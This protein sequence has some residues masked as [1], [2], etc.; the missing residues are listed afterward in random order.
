MNNKYLK[1]HCE[2]RN[3]AGSQRAQFKLRSSQLQRAVAGWHAQCSDKFI[4]SFIFHADPDPRGL[5]YCESLGT[6]SKQEVGSGVK[7]NLSQPYRSTDSRYSR[8][9][10]KKLQFQ[11]TV[12]IPLST[13]MQRPTMTSSETFSMMAAASPATR[14]SSTGALYRFQNRNSSPR[15]AVVEPTWPNRLEVLSQNIRSKQRTTCSGGGG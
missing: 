15:L 3:T 1:N 10:T 13:A 8:I 9:K 2:G 14:A 12:S 6:D 4:N 7:T 11:P 5:L